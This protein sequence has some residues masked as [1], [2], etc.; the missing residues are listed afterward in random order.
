MADLLKQIAEFQTYT[1]AG[2]VPF[3]YDNVVHDV[4]RMLTSM[5]PAEARAL[6]RKFRKL[7]RN[8]A[9]RGSEK[10]R[11][12]MGLGAPHPTRSN[13]KARKSFVFLSLLPKVNE[14]VT[15]LASRR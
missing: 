2:I 7:W 12:H 8:L 6:K 11:R 15:N 5:S 1:E 13:K 10:K 3:S 9:H 4:N 14:T